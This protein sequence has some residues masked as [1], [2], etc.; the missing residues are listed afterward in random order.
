MTD[1][2]ADAA[3]KR[4]VDAASAPKHIEKEL[5][6]RFRESR[7][8]GDRSIETALAEV[9]IIKRNVYV[10][11]QERSLTEEEVQ[12]CS[13]TLPPD[14]ESKGCTD[15]CINRSLL[16]ECHP[17]HCPCGDRCSNQ[18]IQ[19]G[20]R[21]ATKII[22][23]GEK[24]LGLVTLQP[25]RS[26]EF[27][28][29]YMGEIVTEQEYLMRR[30][31]YHNEKHRYMMVLS[32]GE[33]IDATRMGGV[34]RFINHSCQPNCGV[35]KW[36]VNG[37]ERCGIFALRDI[38]PGEELS[39]DYKFQCFSKLEIKRC[40]CN[41]PQCRGYIG[42]NNKPSKPS[43]KSAAG[44]TA[45][46]GAL[47]P[48]AEKP[49]TRDP[50]TAK[51]I[52]G[53]K[54]AD[55]C[56]DRLHRTLASQRVLNKREIEFVKRS[57]VMLVR[58]LARGLDVNFRCIYLEPFFVSELGKLHEVPD[59]F[60]PR[61]LPG[62]PQKYDPHARSPAEKAARLL[63]LTQRLATA[64]EHQ[65][66]DGSGKPFGRKSMAMSDCVH[67]PQAEEG[68]ADRLSSN[69]H[70][71]S[72]KRSYS[73]HAMTSNNRDCDDAHECRCQPSAAES[74][75]F[76]KRWLLLTESER[77]ASLRADFDQ[78][79]HTA[80]ELLP[81]LGCRSST[82]ALFHK[83]SDGSCR[84]PPLVVNSG[85]RFEK[86]RG[87]GFRLSDTYLHDSDASLSLFLHQE[88]WGNTTLAKLGRA[89]KSSS[90]A[91]CP[92]HTQRARGRPRPAAFEVMWNKLP[93]EHQRHLAHIDSDQ[94][95]TDLECYLRR[96]RFCCRCKEKV[97]E[98]Y[99]L[100]IGSSCS[101][102]DC[103]DCAGFDCSDKSHPDHGSD[104][105]DDLHYTSYLF[106][107]LCYSRATS[108]IIVPCH[109][110]YMSQLMTRADQEI[111]GDWGDRHARTIAE[112]QDE[113]L[114]C[115][116]MVI[117]EKMQNLWTKTRSEKQSEELLVHCAVSTIRKNFDI[118]VEAL[119]GKEMMEQLLAEEDDESRRLAK[120]KEKRKEKKKKRK[121]ATKTKQGDRSMTDKNGN[122]N[123][124][125]S[126]KKS[127]VEKSPTPEVNED[128]TNQT[129][130]G[131]D[132]DQDTASSSPNHRCTS[133]CD[134]DRCEMRNLALDEAM[135][136]QLLS[137]MGWDAS[138]QVGLSLLDLDLD[139]DDDEAGIPEDEIEMWKQN[140][141][142]LVSKR[143]EQ[144]QQLQEKFDQFVLRTNSMGDNQ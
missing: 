31:L 8:S 29:E 43:A 15:D 18:R 83:L 136:M 97:L 63:D 100:L 95:L 126:R 128:E 71:H 99:D 81:C 49:R 129:D 109:I 141:A 64:A 134:E 69:A 72:I 122:G 32:G 16:I 91:R 73:H 61:K 131:D 93:E 86:G 20:E 74:R 57:R 125:S 76:R 124:T 84:P 5:E 11:R 121:N 110:D 113:V 19:R 94:F 27:V 45:L 36:E 114:T 70:S 25:V 142:T 98:A 50:I 52:T 140:Q 54:M 85:L 75:E 78:F 115:L 38:Y 120:K 119:H 139:S 107:E 46:A 144:R 24:G 87:Q 67:E 7:T 108:H 42:I 17:N 21:P 117:W 22:R 96:H 35:E 59:C 68:I 88:R 10:Q 133:S 65:Q 23:C 103:E 118:A 30:V 12:I 60:D 28:A 9:Q 40:L 79:F 80:V 55:S 92:L 123:A 105:S 41:T 62:F 47:N 26:G 48:T 6:R 102:D 51:P 132:D 104:Y 2:V 34:A 135:E 116:G 77:T 39:F 4:P 66:D 111:V 137:S 143:L 56:L 3:N 58:N 127:T 13:C 106:D 138:N 101:E 112:A 89:S 130:S 53:R 37:E 1:V 90:R 82:E 33:V 14:P 44:T